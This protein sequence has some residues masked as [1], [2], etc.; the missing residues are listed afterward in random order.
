MPYRKENS[1]LEVWKPKIDSRTT[2]RHHKKEIIITGVTQINKSIVLIFKWNHKT[3]EVASL[4]RLRL[5]IRGQNLDCK[6]KKG[7][8]VWIASII[9]Y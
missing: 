1:N 2:S 9:S 3:R 7:V 4:K 6:A 8:R 5:I